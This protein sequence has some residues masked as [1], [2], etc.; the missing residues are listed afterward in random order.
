MSHEHLPPKAIFHAPS[1]K[2]R[3]LKERGFTHTEVALNAYP[4][5][6]PD[7][8]KTMKEAHDLGLSCIVDIGI[9]N[10]YIEAF[11]FFQE[12]PW[13]DGDIVALIDEPNRSL[14]KRTPQQIKAYTDTVKAWK[15]YLKT[16]ITLDGT[17]P[18]QYFANSADIL[19]VSYYGRMTDLW[20]VSKISFM[21]KQLQCH[22]KGEVRFIPGTKFSASHIKWQKKWWGKVMGLPLFWYSWTPDQENPKWAKEELDKTG[23]LELL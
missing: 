21:V 13:R 8:F 2:Y 20:R 4:G 17:Q 18:F 15:P 11:K 14:N 12:A 16:L 23:W 5:N 6:Y 22:H 3:L 7:M 19:A 10:D 9:K 1:S